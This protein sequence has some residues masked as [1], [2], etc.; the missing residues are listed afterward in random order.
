M[1]KMKISVPPSYRGRADT[2]DF[3]PSLILMS[4]GKGVKCQHTSPSAAIIEGDKETLLEILNEL[5]NVSFSPIANGFSI[6]MELD[7]SNDKP[8]TGSEIEFLSKEMKDENSKRSK[9]KTKSHKKILHD[10]VV[11]RLWRYTRKEKGNR[12]KTSIAVLKQKIVK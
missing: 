3:M 2:G 6:A 5:D 1:P 9:K 7:G 11:K 8:F 12:V 10:M 4:K